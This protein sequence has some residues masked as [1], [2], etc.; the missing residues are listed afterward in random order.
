MKLCILCGAV[1]KNEYKR[2]CFK[3][4]RETINNYLTPNKQPKKDKKK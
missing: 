2:I 4:H 3:C 1:A